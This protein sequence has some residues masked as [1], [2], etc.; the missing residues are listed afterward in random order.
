MEILSI[1]LI[2]SVGNLQMCVGTALDI[3]SVGRKSAISC[4][5]YFFTARRCELRD[6][7][8]LCTYTF[9]RKWRKQSRQT[10][11]QLTPCGN[12]FTEST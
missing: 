9:W 6:A 12:K 3:C 2:F 7:R 5:A 4:S 8:P 11:T 10:S 1:L